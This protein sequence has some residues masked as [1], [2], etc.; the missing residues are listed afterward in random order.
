MNWYGSGFITI[1]NYSYNSSSIPSEDTR[2]T[3]QVEEVR[4]TE[5]GEIRVIE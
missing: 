4:I 3:E 2:V 1:I 5:N